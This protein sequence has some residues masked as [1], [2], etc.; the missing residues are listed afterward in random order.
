MIQFPETLITEWKI[1]ADAANVDAELRK[2]I[3]HATDV[4]LAVSKLRIR[5][6]AA[7]EFQQEL[8]AADTPPVVIQ[9]MADYLAANSP[10]LVDM[11]EG[12]MKE[13]GLILML[14]PSGS[15]KSTLGVQLAHSLLTGDDWLGCPVQ[16]IKGSVGLLSY[17]Q[18]VS[19]PINWMSKMGVPHD[20]VLP[21]DLNGK[22][23]PLNVPDERR[24]LAAAYRAAKVEVVMIDSFSAAFSGDQNDAGLVMAWY[25]DVKKFAYSE[26]GA[27]ALVVIVHSTDSS[28]LKPRGSTVHKDVADTVVAVVRQP[29]NERK[30]EMV[31]YRAGLNQTEMEPVIVTAPDSVTHLVDLDLGAMTLAGMHL[32]AG[33]AAQ[34]FPALPPTYEE[35]DTDSDSG[36][37]G[38]DL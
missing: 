32:P 28:P 20:R 14:G 24:R 10:V 31:K 2:K 1:L 25:R 4:E 30:V 3:K 6:E 8:D 19:I 21:I 11:V 13:D 33:A 36:E 22:G 5:H 15:G 29:T 12:V 23:N 18:N 9:T 26:V 16:Q 38:D 35:A 37:D 27:K 17:D 7:V 34:A